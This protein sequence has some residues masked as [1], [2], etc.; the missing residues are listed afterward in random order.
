[1]NIWENIKEYF[2]DFLERE[3]N[4]LQK[5]IAGFLLGIVLISGILL[6]FNLIQNDLCEDQILKLV[7]VI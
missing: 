5:M 1:M 6:F 3:D 4:I 7:F 2:L